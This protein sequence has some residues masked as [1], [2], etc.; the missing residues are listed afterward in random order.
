MKEPLRKGFEIIWPIHN[1]DRLRLRT[2]NI[3]VVVRNNAIRPQVLDTFK[4]FRTPSKRPYSWEA[5]NLIASL[6]L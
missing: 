1:Q 5:K 2:I 4:E 6:I 3:F